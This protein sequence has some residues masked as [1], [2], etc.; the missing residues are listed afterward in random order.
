[1]RW[2][3]GGTSGDIED[4]RDSSGG[5]GFGGFGGMHLGIGGTILVLVLSF[6]FRQNLFNTVAP[7]PSHSVGSADREQDA[8]E[9]TEVQFVSFVLD[10]VQHTWDQVLPA[11]GRAYTHAKLVLFR[12]SIDSAC[13]MAGSA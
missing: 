2:M 11:D 4:R 5:G 8:T 7:A 6:L 9:K 1:M 10:D 13:G 12:D 3:P